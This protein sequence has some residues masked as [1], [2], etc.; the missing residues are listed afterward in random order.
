MNLDS[1]SRIQANTAMLLRGGPSGEDPKAAYYRDPDT[2]FLMMPGSRRPDGTWR[3]PR[4]V[5]E[6]YLPQDEVPLY[7][8]KGKR[9][10]SQGSGIPGLS[11]Q[12][13]D[14]KIETFHTP[15]TSTLIPGLG[16][17]NM[18]PSLN[19]NNPKS[20]KKKQS[21]QSSDSSKASPPQPVPPPQPQQPTTDPLKKLRNLKKKLRDIEALE[22]RLNAGEISS[23]E[24]EQLQKV[25]R[26][27]SVKIEIETLEASLSA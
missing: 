2:G 16:F 11:K 14:M 5:K 4:R 24:P 8:S 19:S 26:K 1:E 15:K 3:K 13:M 21:Q 7:E 20:K 9:M 18:V 22:I 10:M 6:G 23:P 12:I 17:A 27:E 25:A